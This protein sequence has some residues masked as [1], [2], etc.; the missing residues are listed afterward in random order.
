MRSSLDAAGIQ[1]EEILADSPLQAR[2]TGAVLATRGRFC[3]SH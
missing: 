3:L 1:K 2:A